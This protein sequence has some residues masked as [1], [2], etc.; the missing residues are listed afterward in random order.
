MNIIGV[1]SEYNPFHNGHEYHLLRSREVVGG[2]S[3]VVCVMSGDFVQRGEAAVFSKFAR[4][5]AACKSGAD[6]VIELPLPW[7]LSS[8]EGFARGSVGLLEALGVSHLS[9]GSEEGNIKPLEEIADCLLDASVID[10]IKLLMSR[11]ANLSYASAR[12]TVLYDILGERAELLKKP[13]NILGIEYIK[14]IH[15][16]SLSTKVITVTRSGS[17]HDEVYGGEGPR[18]ASELRLMLRQGADIS[19]FVPQSAADVFKREIEQGRAVLDTAAIETAMLSRLRL[20][21]EAYYNS[22]PDAADGLGNR[23][24]KAVM[25]QPGLNAIHEATKTKRYA[26]SRI[27]RMCVSACLG[28]KAGMNEGIPPYARV[29]AANE[30]GCAVMRTIKENCSIPMISKPATARS[31]SADCT[32]LF[33]NGAAAHDF[34]V[35]GYSGA[36]QKKAG[37]DWKTSPVIVKNQQN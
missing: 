8:A 10:R 20:F 13:N 37:L 21:D 12:Q 23:L 9:F 34:F 6:L 15:E 25:E 28:I 18:S 14:A 5:E 2:D 19:S 17:G 26:M 29:L 35:L 11:E 7:A 1:V 16:N 24:Y 3:A 4:A 33:A 31:L 30:K 27:R 32:K 22:L 36:G